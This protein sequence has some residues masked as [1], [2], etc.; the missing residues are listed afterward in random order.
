MVQGGYLFQGWSHCRVNIIPK[1]GVLLFSQ[2]S[3]SGSLK[4]WAEAGRTRAATRVGRV[5]IMLAILKG[6]IMI[7]ILKELRSSA[8]IFV[9]TNFG[10]NKINSSS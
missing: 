9:A 2:A 5:S 10:P 8:V 7:G 6:G 4:I 3:A 1:T